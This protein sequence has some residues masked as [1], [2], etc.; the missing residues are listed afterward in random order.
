M[1]PVLTVGTATYLTSEHL[2]EQLETRQQTDS[3]NLAKA[4]ITLN[5]RVPLLLMGTGTMA[6]LAGSLTLW[7]MN[8]E[9]RPLIR[10]TQ[11]STQIVNRLYRQPATSESETGH[12]NEVVALA[13]NIK[14]IEDQLLGLLLIEEE[15][16]ARTQLL[17]QFNGQLQVARSEED[18]LQTAVAEIR[19]LFRSDRVL[20][21]ALQP[22]GNGTFVAESVAAGYSKLEWSTL[23]DPCF[24]EGYHALYRQGRVRAIDNIYEVG[25]DDCHI[26]LLERFAVKANIVAPV[27]QQ[28]ELFGLLIA[29]QCSR[30]REWSPSEIELFKQLALQ[31][32]YALERV[33][34]M[35][36]LD[37]QINQMQML[38]GITQTI[39]ES[40]RPEDIL[41]ATVQESRRLLRADRVIVYR[42]DENGL[43]T[44]V[45]EAV[46]PGITKMRSAQL[47]DLG[48]AEADIESYQTGHIQVIH[49]ISEAGFTDRHLQQ[50]QSFG[51]QASLIVP[52]HQAEQLFGLLIA[53]HCSTP[54]EWQSSE[55]DLF[56]Q[57]GLQVGQALNQSHILAQVEQDWHTNMTITHGDRQRFQVLQTQ[58]SEHLRACQPRVN[59]LVQEANQSL[60][61]AQSIYTNLQTLIAGSKGVGTTTQTFQVHNQQ[62]LAQVE[63]V[64][65]ALNQYMTDHPPLQ[66]AVQSE[67][68]QGQGVDAP[69]QQL[70]QI[71][72]LV[73]HLSSQIQLQ[74]MTIAVKATQEVC[75]P[76]ELSSVA[77]TVTKIAQQLDENMIQMKSLIEDLQRDGQQTATFWEP[78]T[79][80]M[81]DP[82]SFFPLSG[83]LSSDLDVAIAQSH[84][85]AAEINQLISRQLQTSTTASHQILEL[86]HFLQ[87][88]VTQVQSI[89]QSINQLET[90]IPP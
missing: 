57:I 66:A 20:I 10:I 56:T 21:F 68:F 77:A 78:L 84:T 74:A 73:G 69:L 65:D 43:G 17:V 50:L 53:H 4:Q 1:L 67:L 8:R 3:A 11:H 35:N 12:P 89:Q 33:G 82:S 29:H 62:M 31:V 23:S 75:P 80:E 34:I 13:N 14:L 44:V 41:T 38:M 81:M 59:T 25:L 32:G 37:S 18:L 48:F 30:P 64:Q 60:Q 46:Q 70:S 40:F 36:Q 61:T 83:Q 24:N 51:V 28:G 71:R 52:L 49:N 9:L 86:T 90:V 47:E 76:Q 15:T 79:R 7:L 19:E 27:L 88:L 16:T 55:V 26:G 45:A 39:R 63:M 2:H 72:T 54:R 58:L 22:D 5:Q 42:F 85:Q 6:L 87:D